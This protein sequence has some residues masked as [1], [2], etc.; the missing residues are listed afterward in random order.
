L[1]VGKTVGK[2]VE[3]MVGMTVVYWVVQRVEL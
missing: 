3:M 1:L 2:R